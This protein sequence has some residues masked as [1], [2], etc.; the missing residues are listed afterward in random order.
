[1]KYPVLLLAALAGSLISCGP[2]GSAPKPET[3][4]LNRSENSLSNEPPPDSMVAAPSGAGTALQ[5]RV[6]FV[7]GTAWLRVGGSSSAEIPVLPDTVL[8]AADRVRT[9]ADATVEVS[10]GSLAT[11]RI[12]PQSECTILGLGSALRGGASRDRAELSLGLGALLVKVRK[13]AGDDE[14]LIQTP[15]TAAGVRGT[16]YLIRY[17]PEK[18]VESGN[19]TAGIT[20]VAVRS[21]RVAVLPKGPLLTG[22]LDGRTAN[23]LAGAVVATAF[24]FAPLVGPGQELT[25]GGTKGSAAVE[26]AESRYAALVRTAEDAQAQGTDFGEIT[27]APSLLA[28]PASALRRNLESLGSRIP[29]T[30]LSDTSKTYL[31]FL[32][33]LREPGAGASKLP[34]AFPETFFSTSKAPP[35]AT[36]P[37]PSYPYL[38]WQKAVSSVSLSEG[39]GHVGPFIVAL[40]SRGLIHCLDNQGRV[41]WTAGPEV[42]AF[43]PLEQTVA[44]VEKS[45]LRI[46]DGQSGTELGR[47]TYPGWAALPQYKG[48]PVPQGI[49]MATPQGVMILRQENAQIVKEIPLP[50]G[51]IAPL[52][53]MDKRLAAYSGSGTLYFISADTAAVVGQVALNMGTEI[54]TPR[55]MDGQGYFASRQGRLV[56]VDTT[57][58]QILWDRFL[59]AEIKADPELDSQRLYLWTGD[60]SLRRL[61]TR[62]GSDVGTPLTAVDSPPLLSQGRLYLGRGKSLVIADAATLAVIQTLPLPDTPAGRPLMID[63]FLYIGSRDG[64]L[65]RLDLTK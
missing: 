11:V 23:P 2:Q 45:Q 15:N 34:A 30:G 18:S 29:I 37:A 63:G 59:S 14:F 49:A 32:D 13:L 56:A 24:A 42:L 12:L 4:P 50:G 27:D 1:M 38:R 17:G 65:M 25:I 51:V 44:L 21:G 64:G 62:D 5:A 6:T 28:P 36:T 8:Q 53:L 48:V 41:L 31:L 40:D 58:D 35:S 47:W 26:E 61:S 57:R 52:V 10:Y 46:V 16:E 39:I 7:Q 19:R 54:L 3:V 43:T 22:L 60:H 9:E 20:T 55:Y 33:R